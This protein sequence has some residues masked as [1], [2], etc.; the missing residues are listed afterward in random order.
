M[1]LDDWR[2]YEVPAGLEGER[3]DTAIARLTGLSRTKAAELVDAA[4][5]RLDGR[6]PAR[7][8]RVLGGMFIDVRIESPQANEEDRQPAGSAGSADD[9][10]ELS[11]LFEDDAIVV[12]DKP[13]GVAA[14]SSPGWKG[15]TVTSSL[16]ALGVGL[17]VAGAAERQGI[18]HRLD[19]GTSGVMVVAKSDAAYSELKRQF[20]ART[21]SKIYHA[22]VQ[23]HPDP[24]SG[25][26]DA[27]IGR[28]P[29]RDY[30]F[31]VVTGGR[32]SITH[33]GTL[34]AFRR[35]SLLEVQLETGR[36]HQIRVHMAAIRHPC[37]GDLTYGADPTL[38]AELRIERQWLHAVALEIDHPS[39]GERMR[40]ES[41]YPPDLAAAL[42]T[43]RS[44]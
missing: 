10:V 21:V 36:T 30:R 41:E 9:T 5:V 16:R 8:H 17:A 4:E 34:E 27:P 15:P 12:I 23:G 33:Y 31:A 13:V 20:K 37:C 28:H 35:T 44:W 24:S 26:V 32:D 38:A 43:C 29:H 11:R 6:A 22:L 1:T 39:H 2:R 18:V 7:S 42:R 25:T 40:F 19:V 14:H 3:I